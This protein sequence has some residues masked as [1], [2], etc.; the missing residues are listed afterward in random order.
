G[1]NADTQRDEV[2]KN[3]YQRLSIGIQG[4]PMPA[5]RAVEEGNQDPIS[6]ED[7]WHVANYVYSLRDQYDSEPSGSGVINGIKVDGILPNKVD[8]PIWQSAKASQLTLVPNII[9]DE[10]L[11][12]PLNNSITV[13]AVFNEENIAFLLQINDRTESRPGEAVSEAIQDDE[14]ELLSDAIAIQLP[15]QGAYQLA[16][17]V[18]KPLFRHGD[19]DHPVTLWYW[20]A[21][22][23]EPVQAPSSLLLEG[24][25]PDTPLQP[26]FGDDSLLVQQQWQDGQWQIIMQRPRTGSEWGDMEFVEG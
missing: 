2:V 11:F 8:D 9:K 16:P 18:E 24:H 25:G 15:K 22:S 12:T 19:K 17:V 20:N 21:G 13:R 26:R 14:L 5:H 1:A 23:E 7:R 3:I 10:R 4:T 6:L